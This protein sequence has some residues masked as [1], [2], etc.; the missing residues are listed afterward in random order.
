MMNVLSEWIHFYGDSTIYEFPIP[1]LG[2]PLLKLKTVLPIGLMLIPG[3]GRWYHGVDH[4]KL[5]FSADA[6]L[7]ANTD[8]QST[9]L[10]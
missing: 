9:V 7:K 5:H 3:L 1:T 6:G 8:N 4:V 2:Q 10:S